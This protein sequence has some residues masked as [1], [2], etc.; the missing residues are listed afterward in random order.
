LA[1]NFFFEIFFGTTE[2]GNDGM[3]ER[4]TVGAMERGNNGTE[5]WNDGTREQLE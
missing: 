3:K 5:R 1:R 2:R 4:W